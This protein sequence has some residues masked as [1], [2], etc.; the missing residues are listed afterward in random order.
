VGTS[1]S[2]PAFAGMMALVVQ[3]SNSRQGNPNAVLYNVANRQ[4]GVFHDITAGTISMPCARGSANCVT[5]NAAHEIGLLAGY[6]AGS[7]YD[8]ATG[9]GSV[10]AFDLVMAAGWVTNSRWITDADNNAT[11][12]VPARGAVSSTTPGTRPSVVTGY[13]SLELSS[14]GA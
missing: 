3:N 10:N 6:D 13:A 5:A 1:I 9:L 12:N 8:L 2:G 11:F 4:S 14:G 7:G